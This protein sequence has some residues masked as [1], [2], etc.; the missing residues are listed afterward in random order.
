MPGCGGAKQHLMSVLWCST[1]L[2]SLWTPATLQDA[3]W[4]KT[5]EAG[6]R[7]PLLRRLDTQMYMDRNKQTFT[8]QTER[9]SETGDSLHHGSQ[10]PGL[11]A[12]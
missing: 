6:T 9:P 8:L 2:P 5:Q 10:H 3:I 4:Q 11:L 1:L 7:S 12:S